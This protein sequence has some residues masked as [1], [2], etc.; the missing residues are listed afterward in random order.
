MCSRTQGM[1]KMGST[2]SRYASVGLGCGQRS[3]NLGVTNPF[4][5]L[6]RALLGNNGLSPLLSAGEHAREILLF[7]RPSH[8]AGK[9]RTCRFSTHDLLRTRFGAHQDGTVEHVPYDL[10]NR[11]T[12]L[13][14][15]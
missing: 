4:D 8:Q 9:E 10:F 6:T 2:A 7:E 5:S 14:L 1:M 15:A 12:A 11:R 13:A 3:R